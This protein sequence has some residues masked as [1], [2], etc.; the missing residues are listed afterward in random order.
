MQLHG[1]APSQRP[2]AGYMIAVAVRRQQRQRR[3]EPLGAEV[4]RSGYAIAPNSRIDHD[5]QAAASIF[6]H[7]AIEDPPR[8]SQDP[9]IGIFVPHVP[10]VTADAHG[11]LSYQPRRGKATTHGRGCPELGRSPCPGGTTR[12]GS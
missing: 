5:G 12:L 6:D 7:I 9:S 11:S 4:L 1:G 2:D 10:T 8:E 3:I